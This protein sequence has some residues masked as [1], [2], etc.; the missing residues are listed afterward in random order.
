M[1]FISWSNGKRYLY[2][3]KKELRVEAEKQFKD[4]SKWLKDKAPECEKCRTIYKQ[5]DGNLYTPCNPKALI[6][7]DGD[8]LPDKNYD[9]NENTKL[10]TCK[11]KQPLFEAH[12]SQYVEP[13]FLANRDMNGQR[14]N[15]DIMGLC[16]WINR[17]DYFF[18]SED[19]LLLCR[20]A[21][22]V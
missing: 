2:Y 13:I 19:V 4:Y 11:N 21:R 14:L 6:D 10:Y 9:Y 20:L 1:E 15:A 17:D 8:K 5:S 22:E 3:Q 7:I 12:I 18:D 16:E